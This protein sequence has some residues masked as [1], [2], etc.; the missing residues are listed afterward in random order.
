MGCQVYKKKTAQFVIKT[1]PITFWGK[2][3]IKIAPNYYSRGAPNLLPGGST[4]VKIAFLE[5]GEFH[6]NMQS[7]KQ[8]V[9]A[10]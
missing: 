2:M 10:V 9:A 7:K 1:N 8:P 6:F 3:A 4:L 5:G